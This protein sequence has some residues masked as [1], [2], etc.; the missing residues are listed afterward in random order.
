MVPSVRVNLHGCVTPLPDCLL[1]ITLAFSRNSFF[2]SSVRFGS[3]FGFDCPNAAIAER[4]SQA[5]IVKAD[6]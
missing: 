5:N 1:A 2:C 4:H 3:F 6:E